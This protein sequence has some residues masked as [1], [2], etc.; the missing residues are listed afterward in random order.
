M[1]REKN[2][3][4]KIKTQTN[5][6]KMLS[7]QDF[8]LE[9]SQFDGNLLL[10]TCSPNSTNSIVHTALNTYAHI[11]AT[12]ACMCCISSLPLQSR[13]CWTFLTS[14]CHRTNSQ[15]KKTT[16]EKKTL[17]NT[18]TDPFLLFFVLLSLSQRFCYVFA[19]RS[20][21]ARLNLS[22]H[23]DRMNMYSGKKRLGDKC[24]VRDI[25]YTMK[26]TDTHTHNY[27][28]IHKHKYTSRRSKRIKSNIHTCT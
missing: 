11:H 24:C 2:W 12:H 7:A 19:F 10:Y 6:R 28:E 9:W 26:H 15:A 21:C 1:I 4:L 17:L 27:I 8:K 13:S 3:V 16:N 18:H 5:E 20:V 14:T 25:V 23:W 22:H